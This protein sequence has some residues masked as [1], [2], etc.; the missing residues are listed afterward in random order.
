ML[1]MVGGAGDAANPCAHVP[2]NLISKGSP[3]KD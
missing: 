1:P 3:I 2:G